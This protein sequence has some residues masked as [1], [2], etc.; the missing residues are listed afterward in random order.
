MRTLEL[1][2]FLEHSGK[3]L[4]RFAVELRLSPPK[5]HYWRHNCNCL[6]DFEGEEVR[7]I[8]LVK[9]KVVYEQETKTVVADISG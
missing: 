3:S 1:T 2:E 4:H 5:V 7:A 8:R 9:E 6:V